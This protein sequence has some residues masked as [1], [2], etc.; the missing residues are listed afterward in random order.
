MDKILISVIKECDSLIKIGDAVCS[1]GTEDRLQGGD[2]EVWA[3]G[4]RHLEHAARS[5]SCHQL[6]RGPGGQPEDD[7]DVVAC[8]AV[9][10]TIV[11]DA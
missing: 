3:E 6:V 1:S 8:G 7:P 10:V 4:L 9:A 11:L 5:I 2:G